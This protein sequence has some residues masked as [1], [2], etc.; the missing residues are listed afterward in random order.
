[1]DLTAVLL[2][3]FLCVCLT[4]PCWGPWRC[5]SDGLKRRERAEASKALDGAE[6]PRQTAAKERPAAPHQLS[7]RPTENMGA[8]VAEAARA[9]KARLASGE[10]MAEMAADLEIDV[11]RL[12]ERD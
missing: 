11:W 6:E 1:M 7:R 9:V 3:C 4:V 8:D 5:G 10:T 2:M 12:D